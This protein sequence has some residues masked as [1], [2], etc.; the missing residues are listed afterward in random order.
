[1]V[2]VTVRYLFYQ[3]MPS[4]NMEKTLF[5]WPIVWQCDVKANNRLISRKLSGRKLSV[6]LA[7]QKHVRLYPFDKPIKSLYFRSV[8]VSD[9]LAL[10]HFKVIE[11]C[12]KPFSCNSP[13]L[14]I[15][16]N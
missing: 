9:L 3:P 11:N 2:S 5:D 15:F 6:H 12:S 4:P 8:V 10:F 16:R 7:N 14:V 1:M 13:F